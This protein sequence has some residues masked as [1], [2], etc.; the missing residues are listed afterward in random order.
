MIMNPG[1]N[2]SACTL[3]LPGGYR[4]TLVDTP[5]TAPL[6]NESGPGLVMLRGTAQ[7]WC[8]EAT[9]LHAGVG[10]GCLHARR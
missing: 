6:W 1:L 10:Q 9:G 8:V 5:L 7:S 3:F 2:P 4:P